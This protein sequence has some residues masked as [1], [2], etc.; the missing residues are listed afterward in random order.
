MIPSLKMRVWC[1]IAILHAETGPAVVAWMKILLQQI[2]Q[3]LQ[4]TQHLVHI[5]RGSCPL[6]VPA[7]QGR[8]AAACS[9]K[10]GAATAGGAAQSGGQ[11]VD[12]EL[13][14]CGGQGVCLPMEQC[15]GN[16]G[17]GTACCR[18]DWI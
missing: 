16:R 7:P 17:V 8:F 11:S 14:G 4:L 5:S 15:Y 10:L 12:D 18:Q 9:G 6:W 3:L 1:F 2:N 13:A